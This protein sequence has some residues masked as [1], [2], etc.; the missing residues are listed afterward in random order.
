MVSKDL[1]VVLHSCYTFIY[2]LFCKKY[3]YYMTLKRYFTQLIRINVFSFY[4]L[5]KDFYLYTFTLFYFNYTVLSVITIYEYR[6]LCLFL[7]IDRVIFG[8]GFDILFN[9]RFLLC[10]SLYLCWIL[11]CDS[12][13]LMPSISFAGSFIYLTS[14]ELWRC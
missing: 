4:L 10:S 14:S 9:L 8:W 6:Q 12:F 3:I 11:S 5:F 13:T 2:E 1:L 7:F